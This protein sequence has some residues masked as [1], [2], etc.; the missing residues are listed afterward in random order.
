MKK[1]FLLSVACMLSL[2]VSAQKTVKFENNQA[3]AFDVVPNSYVKP[4]TVEL[5]IDE[6][7]GRITDVWEIRPDELIALVNEKDAGD[8]QMQN[9]RNYAIFKSSQKHNCDVI[10][11]PIFN[12]RSEDV[13]RGVTV[14]LIGFCANFV[15]WKTMDDKDVLWMNVERAD[16]R[17]VGQ[18][19]TPYVRQ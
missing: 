1:L 7:K 11:A 19:Y 4:L 18:S 5:K 2:A 8:V 17:K 15:N 6:Q 10:V 12:I 14:T 13:S 16:P 3:R 9:L